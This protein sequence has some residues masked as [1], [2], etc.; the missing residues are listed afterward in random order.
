MVLVKKN[1]SDARERSKPVRIAAVA[2]LV[3]NANLSGTKA[4]EKGVLNLLGQFIPRC[5]IGYVK[6]FANC[7]QNLRIVIGVAKEASKNTL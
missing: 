1:L 5:C 4:T 7:R 6:M 2:R 3:V